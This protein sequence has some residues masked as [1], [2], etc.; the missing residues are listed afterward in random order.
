MLNLQYYVAFMLFSAPESRSMYY[1]GT[2][3]MLTSSHYCFKNRNH[4]VE[5][6]SENQSHE[7]SYQ[8][9]A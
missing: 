2:P 7:L 4:L 6:C 8:M 5:D 3:S 1:T 9:A